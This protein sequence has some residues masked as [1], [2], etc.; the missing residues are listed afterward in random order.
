M[1]TVGMIYR[2]YD[3]ILSDGTTH[4]LRIETDGMQH[5]LTWHEIFA[6]RM[7]TDS[8]RYSPRRGTDG[9]KH[10]HRGHATFSQMA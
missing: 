1:E 7:E 4:S 8:R 3:N 9:M 6:L 2:R 10:S 5:S